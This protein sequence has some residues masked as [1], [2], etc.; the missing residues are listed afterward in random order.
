LKQTYKTI[1]TI[2][3]REEY[4]YIQCG[5]KKKGMKTYYDNV[6][7]VENTALCLPSF[8][9][10]DGVQKLVGSMLDDQAL[11]EWELH[12]LKDMKWNNNHQLPIK[13]WSR[14][15]IKSMRWLMRQP[16]YP[17]YLIY[18]PQLCF[19]SDTPPKHL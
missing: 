14:D 9:K 15:I 16:A 1:P 7:K 5:I 6:L 13:S 12:T 19:N 11:G 4:K 8:K 2:V 17:E 3:T 18:A 10:G